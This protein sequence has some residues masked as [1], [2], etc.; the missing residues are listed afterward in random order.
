[1]K[2]FA[3]LFVIVVASFSLGFFSCGGVNFIKALDPDNREMELM[4]PE[5]DLPRVDLPEKVHEECIELASSVGVI[6]TLL[7][8]DD[9]I[10]G[11]ERQFPELRVQGAAALVID[12]IVRVADKT[13]FVYHGVVALVFGSMY[14]TSVRNHAC[15]G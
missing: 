10:A 9:I 12:T 13:V 3:I 15:E 2:D 8:D 6:R 1:M 7:G 5:T 11:P 14:A 4:I